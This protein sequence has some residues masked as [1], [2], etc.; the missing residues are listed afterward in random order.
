MKKRTLNIVITFCAIAT[1]SQYV[2]KFMVPEYPIEFLISSTGAFLI[3]YYIAW[4][5]KRVNNDNI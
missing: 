1:F 2:V 4:R 5:M 3:I